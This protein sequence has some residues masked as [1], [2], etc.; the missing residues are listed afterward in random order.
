MPK[1]TTFT[2]PISGKDAVFTIAYSLKRG[3]FYAVLPLWMAGILQTTE[4]IGKTHYAVESSLRDAIEKYGKLKA[5][6]EKVIF[7]VF[8]SMVRDLN[9]EG[10][11]SA[12]GLDQMCSEGAALD[13]WFRVGYVI[14][15]PTE[16]QEIYLNENHEK[17]RQSG[18]FGALANR[19]V[20]Y[21]PYT[22][23]REQFFL[24]FREWLI[25]GIEKM[26]SFFKETELP[27]LMDEVIRSQKS[28][29]FKASS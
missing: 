8:K 21:M 15:N 12:Q 18:V 7:Y 19:W 20:H 13:L 5:V 10:D 6:E 26:Q 28:L 24:A 3:E 4:V 11:N 27:A 17:P 29:P 25:S 23:E 14:R 2:F 16:H 9:F 1:I 22:P